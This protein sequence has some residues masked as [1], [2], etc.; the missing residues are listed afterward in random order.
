M[1]IS[2]YVV[3]GVTHRDRNWRYRVSCKKCGHEREVTQAA[4]KDAERRQHRFCRACTKREYKN[5]G[6]AHGE[7]DRVRLR[8]KTDAEIAKNN[9]LMRQWPAAEGRRGYWLWADHALSA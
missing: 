4:L 5:T 3:L 6:L 8:G 9:S 1:S 7:A 2:Q